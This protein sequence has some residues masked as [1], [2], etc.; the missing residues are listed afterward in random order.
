MGVPNLSRPF[1]DEL[2]TARRIGNFENQSREWHDLR[3]TGIGG[4]DVAAIVGVSPWTSPFTLWAKKTGRIVD[5]SAPSEAAE[6]GT[7]LE[8]VV[9]DKFEETN[10]NLTVFREVGTWQH[11]ERDF[12]LANPD[13][14]YLNEDGDYGIIEVKTSRYEDDWTN[15][16]PE[17]YKT[18][19]RWYAQTFGFSSRIYVVALFAGSKYKVF[20]LEADAFE[21][22]SNLAKVEAFLPY[23]ADDSQPDYDGS[24]STYATVRELHPEIDPDLDVELGELFVHYSLALND[25]KQA[26]AHANEMKSRVLDALGSAKRGLYNDKVVVVRQSRNGGTPYLV[27]KKG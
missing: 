26:V 5:E 11:K 18:Q 23:L 16:V 6:W 2:G 20:E 15:G 13:A 24:L 22:E 1:P 9:L 14:I 3:K 25:E 7:R 27:N 21:E 10:P 4:S 12:Q 8:S 19:V 17:Y